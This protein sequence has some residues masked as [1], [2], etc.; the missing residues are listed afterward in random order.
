MTEDF[1]Q[2]V[3]LYST[4]RQNTFSNI[5][6]PEYIL[7][8]R[9]YSLTTCPSPLSTDTPPLYLSVPENMHTRISLLLWTN[10]RVPLS[11]PIKRRETRPTA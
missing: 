9:E 5:K 10:V 7:L 6:V 4:G 3:T 2:N 11:P 8:I 1:T